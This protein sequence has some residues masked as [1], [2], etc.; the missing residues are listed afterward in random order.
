MNGPPAGVVGAL[1]VASGRGAADDMRM[2]TERSIKQLS[3]PSCGKARRSGLTLRNLFLSASSAD[4]A[5]QTSEQAMS[6]DFTLYTSD[7]ALASIRQEVLG[8]GG[9]YVEVAD[10]TN[11][12]VA[13]RDSK[14]RDGSV[15]FR[16]TPTALLT[17]DNRA[18]TFIR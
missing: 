17:Q 4:R 11:G 10:L 8:S 15:L 7:L 14:N 3:F 5:R 16:A 6:S 13:V 2:P 9:Q 18:D 12:R 1:A